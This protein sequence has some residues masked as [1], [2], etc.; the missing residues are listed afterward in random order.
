MRIFTKWDTRVTSPTNRYGMCKTI[1]A[2]RLF[3]TLLI[4]IASLFANTTV[5][6]QTPPDGLQMS[7]TWTADDETNHTGVITLEVFVTGNAISTHSPT[8]IVLV[9]DVSGSMAFGLKNMGYQTDGLS[10]EKGTIPGYYV[11]KYPNNNDYR[12]LRYNNGQWQVNA[13]SNQTGSWSN[14]TPSN[15][16]TI[17]ESRMGALK[18]AVSA[19]VDN[20]S[21]DALLYSVD[22]RISIV[23]FAGNRYYP[24][25]DDEAIVD[26]GDHTYINNGYTY[27]C[28]EVV[29]NRRP[30]YGEANYIKNQVNALVARG[31]TA[32][33]YG[34][35]KAQYVLSQIPTSETNRQKVVVMFTD[36][37]PTH[38]N[39]FD[40][41]V[42]NTTIANAYVL[43]HS[44]TVN[45]TNHDFNAKVFTVG[46]FDN[47][48]NDIRTYMNYTSSNYPD[49]QSMTDGGDEIEEPHFCFTADTPENLQNVFT[50]IAGE[51]G[52]LEIDQN[53]IVQ[54]VISPAFTLP[55]GAGNTIQAFAPKFTRIE[56]G[57]YVFD[58]PNDKDTLTLNE[59]GVVVNGGGE[60]LLPADCITVDTVTKTIKF[61]GF[62]FSEMWVGFNDHTPHGRKLVIKIP[63]EIEE[64]VWG[65]GIET[66]G[67]MS[68]IF[69]NG[70]VAN[71]IGFVSPTA[72]V[73]GDVW[74]EIV[75]FAPDS[76]DDT[77]NP[78]EIGTPEDL[79]WFISY[80]NG[81]AG[82]GVNH[83]IGSHS[84]ANAILTADL[85]MSAHNWIPIGSNGVTYT[86][87]FDG[88]GHVITGL[89]NNASKMYK[90]G[91]NVV[92][93]PGMFGKVS[94]TV[95]DVFVLDCEFRAKK[96][97][98]TKIHYGIIVDTLAQGGMLYNCEAAGKLITNNEAGNETLN[99]GG[100]VGLNQGF[101][102]SCMSMVQLTGFTMGGCV[103]Q[104]AEGGIIQNCMANPAIVDLYVS[105]GDKYPPHP[106][107]GGL[108][109]YNHGTLENSYVRWSRERI[110]D[111]SKFGQ[112]AGFTE[113]TIHQVYVPESDYSPIIDVN[114]DPEGAYAGAAQSKKYGSTVA[115]YL[116]NFN[117]DII[118]DEDSGGEPQSLLD[119]MNVWVSDKN[120]PGND[121]VTY[122]QWKRT[123][124]GNYSAGAGDIN[125]DYPILEYDYACV[126]STDGIVLDYSHSLDAMLERHNEGKL[127]ENTALPG[128][129]SGYIG[130]STHNYHVSAAPAIYGGTINLYKNQENTT[131]S[132]N[133]NVVVYIDEDKSLL[134]SEA[135]KIEAYT[136]QTMKTFCDSD[137]ERW[138]NVS[139]SLANSEIGFSY[140]HND[141]VP[142][143][144]EADPCGV[145]LSKNDD[146][147]LF[148]SDASSVNPFDFYC[149]YEPQYHWINFRRNSKSHWHMD[150]Y[151]LNIPYDNETTLTPG[152]GYL[153]AVD[154]EQFLQNRGT[155]NN[156]DIQIAVTAKA[157]EWSGL[158]G[159]N[160]LGNP[161]QSYLD[162]EEFKTVNSSLWDGE[163]YANTY[164]VYDPESD[165]WLQ[166]AAQAS[167][168]AEVASQYI[169]M[170]Q[171]FMIRVSKEGKANFTNAMRTNEGTPNFRGKQN[172]PLINFMLDNGKDSR[173]V[174]V[175]ELGRPENGGAEKLNVGSTK[176]RIS[177]R[178]DNT[179]FGILFRDI[180]EGSQPLYF[181]T[182]ED[183]TF[184][185]SWNTANANF[186]SLTLVD[187]LTGAR[188]DM[189]A[190]N[191]YSFEGKASDYRSRF[192]VVIGRFTDVEE[193]E[194]VITD[195]F[196]FFDGSDWIV[197]GQGQLTVTDMTGRTVYT[198]NLT[199]DQNRVSL[200]GVANGV[201]LMRVANGQ[202]V[203]VQKIVVR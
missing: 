61:T 89:K 85:D 45:G 200:N 121:S 21:N 4:L 49:A 96:H 164:A 26:E 148:P 10:P 129:G 118:L 3:C 179:D 146:K 43:K 196:A 131:L 40:Q 79:A 44:G 98:G 127:N 97:E 199:N 88:K 28:T 67:P 185:L 189:L 139:S 15:Y 5:D 58:E 149:F 74:T 62:K 190:N 20:I 137:G 180:T 6:A 145:Q 111:G 16:R 37:S 77:K 53:T 31:A 152:K 35:K 81:R 38:G 22:H 114:N 195:N 117:G 8:D 104:N 32:S 68:V 116:Y 82:Y 39:Q 107:I 153:L 192:K 50:A 73:K 51:S 123:T 13:N 14:Y 154:K 94:G 147:A 33:D 42:A 2:G 157:P 136:C 188:Y 34:M 178:H 103:G 155:L 72:N 115:P 166:Y 86:G 119:A 80:V 36:G 159:Y 198:S 83:T 19:F 41:T 130:E 134:Q 193:N 95:H 163:A 12:A 181:E 184:T 46:V 174:A 71:P 132:T 70:D 56:N 197:N 169:N 60:N 165:A 172:Y 170:H 113:G 25:I 186:S 65:D 93:Y 1:T 102:H 75:Q 158:K 183:G 90:Q 105:L 160:L 108:V 110:I 120:N 201:Y 175:L 176:G 17:Y 177:L 141:T 66:N 18:D 161:Y 24:Q 101:V 64:G 100:L 99:F 109:A 122:V 54:D 156:G 203:M 30:A 92:V 151:S 76:F 150:N 144:W 23:K 128:E 11:V 133:D 112:I 182:E 91:Q 124:A 167:D 173:N 27:N 171:G 126:A 194:E 135:S 162:F 168:D 52:A 138:H 57:E 125:D 29:I 48:T 187:N 47:E 143:N 7:K 106:A 140:I 78:I 63:V 84:D 55:K 142:H 202:N 59:N 9:L 87:T 191:S 69:P